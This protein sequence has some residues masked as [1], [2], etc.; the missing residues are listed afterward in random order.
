MNEH[1]TR[2]KREYLKCPGCGLLAPNPAELDRWR[3]PSHPSRG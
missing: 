1:E 2:K 3:T